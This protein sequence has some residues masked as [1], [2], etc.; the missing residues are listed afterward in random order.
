MV[1]LI[2]KMIKLGIKHVA[3]NPDKTTTLEQV[4]TKQQ[5]PIEMDVFLEKAFTRYKNAIYKNRAVA[6]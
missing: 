2:Q 3:Q 5:H 6:R 1:N 4:N